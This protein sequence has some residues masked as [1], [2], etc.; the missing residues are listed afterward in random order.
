MSGSLLIHGAGTIVTGLLDRPRAAGDAILIEEGMVRAI[1]DHADVRPDGPITAVDVGG[2]TLVPGLID[3]HTHPVLGD[4][5]PRQGTL[6]WIT[7]Y[8][9]GGVTS[10]VSAG[11]THW[12]GRPRS[13]VGAKAMAISACLSAENLRPGGA[14][15]NA[16]A[17][18]LEPGLGEADFD[19]MA[20]A[21]VHLLGEIGLGAVVDP[22]EVRPMVAWAHK[23]G[24]TV[25]MHIG[26]ASVPGSHV[27]GAEAALAVQPDIASQT[28][29]GPTARA[30]AE[31]EAILDGTSAAIEVVQ[32]GN[33]RA[34]ADI[35]RMLRERDAV[36]R[37]QI[38]TDTP[39]GTGVVPLGM[40]RTMAYCSA[41]GGL[42]PDAA[43]CAATGGTA[44]RYRLDTGVL[45][46][47]RPGDVV[48]LHAPV[49][50]TA[51]TALDAL[52][53]G[54]TP[55]ISLVAVDGEVLVTRSRVTPPPLVAATVSAPARVAA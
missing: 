26:G 3:P 8:L 16:G 17:L 9:N 21:G 19:E 34:L 37:L 13:G 22:D 28:N 47:G 4:F 42:D 14:K 29:G 35:V 15:L 25:P 11:E 52:A 30:F 24:W 49:G 33:I 48:A 36:D 2:A 43:V 18:L 20:A 50:G 54:D 40:L 27:L 45:A 12:P 51:S 55:G 41:L 10:L 46:P 38:G 6:G 7:S 44:A 5:T 23:H 39:S 53:T 1:G 32:A 31:I